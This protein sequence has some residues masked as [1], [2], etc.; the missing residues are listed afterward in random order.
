MGDRRASSYDAGCS[1]GARAPPLIGAFGMMTCLA[2]RKPMTKKLTLLLSSLLLATA[3]C[4]QDDPPQ[5]TP[6]G[7]G[8]GRGGGNAAVVPDPQPYDRVITKHAKTSKGMF[9]VHQI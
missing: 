8:P 2:V 1:R 3:L 7:P 9:T 6:T 4:A 5:Q